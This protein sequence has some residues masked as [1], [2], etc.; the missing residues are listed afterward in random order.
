MYLIRGMGPIAHLTLSRHNFLINLSPK[1]KEMVRLAGLSQK[2]ISAF[3][4][5][6]A[7]LWLDECGFSSKLYKYLG[8]FHQPTVR[9]GEWGPECITVPGNACGIG[10]ESGGNMHN[11]YGEK[12][13]TL[14]PHN[15]DT[16]QQKM[17]ILMI[18]GELAETIGVLNY[19]AF[20]KPEARDE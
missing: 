11:I 2:S 10:I 3:V 4:N 12:G 17:L 16:L 6:N 19:D 1:F 5:D 13:E 18:F 7:A 14:C 8:G 15:I 9:W 20:Q